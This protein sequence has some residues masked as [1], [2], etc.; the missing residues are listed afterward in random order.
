M[1]IG[2]PQKSRA[3]VSLSRLY[4]FKS[5]ESCL[6]QISHLPALHSEILTKFLP[7]IVLVRQVVLCSIVIKCAAIEFHIA[8]IRAMH[9]YIREIAIKEPASGKSASVNF[10]AAKITA[11]EHTV[12]KS[13]IF[14][15]SSQETHI[16]KGAVLEVALLDRAIIISLPP[17]ILS[18]AL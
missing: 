2:L 10:A 5:K 17:N 3:K 12:D 18:D 9:R 4:L 14:Y 1:P 7:Q 11:K 8:Q 13:C 15:F 6:R 16:T